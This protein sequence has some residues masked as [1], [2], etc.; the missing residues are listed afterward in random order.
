MTWPGRQAYVQWDDASGTT[1]QLAFDC[2]TA[3]D[4]D[5]GATVTEH[6]VEVGA[7]VADHVRVK[8]PTCTLAVRS[9]NEPLA[10]GGP[11]GV[12]PNQQTI[13][14]SVATAGYAPDPSAPLIQKTWFNEIL[15]RSL[16]YTAAGEIS[17]LIPG[18]AGAAVG[19]I[20]AIAVA[21]LFQ[22]HEVDVPV[23]TT[24]PDPSGGFFLSNQ[25]GM[26]R[27]DVWPTGNATDFVLATHSLLVQLKSL[28]QKFTVFGSK[29]TE[30]DMVIETLTIHR[31]AG[32]GTGEALT[33]GF[34][35]V[36]IVST[37]TVALP[38]PHLSAGGATPPANHGAQQTTTPPASLAVGLI[39]SASALIP[40]IVQGAGR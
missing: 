26:V 33:I 5:Q 31:D 36:R 7:D 15:E 23:Q 11:N 3:E 35:Q 37:A 24:L 20:G 4:W 17:N 38:I 13:T 16:G 21:A 18:A 2:V 6:P 27:V 39:N 32:T 8:L 1:N 9:T 22:G 14:L 10:S 19:A 28:A 25:P 29:Q 30:P 34:K 40:Q 12:V